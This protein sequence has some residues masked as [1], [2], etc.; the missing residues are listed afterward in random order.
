MI[1]EQDPDIAQSVAML[2][3]HIMRCVEYKL[4]VSFFFVVQ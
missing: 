2:S 4:F 3:L 1:N